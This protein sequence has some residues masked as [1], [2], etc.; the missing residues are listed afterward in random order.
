MIRFCCEHCA[1]KISVQDKHVSKRVKCSKCGSVIVVPAESTVIDFLCENCERKISV[2]K[3]NSGK[4][5]I[6]PK[7][8]NTFIIPTDQFQGPAAPLSYSGDLI[9]RTT[10]SPHGL[11]L[12]DVPEEYKLKAES[13]G[14][15][16]VS[17]QAVDRRQ[18]SEE[19]SKAEQAESAGS[20]KLP[21]I[22][23]VFLYPFNVPGLKHIV[24]LTGIPLLIAIMTR[25][26]PGF[27]SIL[28]FYV[29]WV[30]YGL[31]LIYM[32]WYISA[33]IRD[34]ADGWIRAP[35]GL[36]A[37]P[38]IV[39]M[40]EQAVNIIGCLGVCFGPAMLYVL[41]TNRFDI[42]FW[43]LLSFA[44]FFCPMGLLAVVIY[45]SPVGI[46]PRVIIRSISDTFFPYCCLALLIF[47]VGVLI[48][49]IVAILPWSQLRPYIFFAVFTYM[50]MVTAHILGCFYFK[51]R[52]KLKWEV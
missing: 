6:C 48:T 26:A 41:F 29:C 19:D 16:N 8:G 14:Q 31:L 32:C 5:A 34:S 27:F 22:L 13:A 18:E 43:G 12:I 49:V 24:I 35:K 9:A 47:A 15:Y 21:W 4:K 38:D 39:D 44:L 46:H 37:V 23:D 10:D 45:D 17:E 11:T 30:V 50:T 52:D 25:V 51:H 40:F 20:R 3:I 1:H 7:C 42:I 28:L 36:G 33:C 2:L